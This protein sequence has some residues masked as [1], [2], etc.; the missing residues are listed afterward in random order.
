MIRYNEEKKAN[1]ICLINIF[2]SI[3][4]EAFHAGQPTVFVRTFGCNL[5]CPFCD[6]KECW[7]EANFDKVYEGK[8]KLSWWTVDEII[9]KVEELEKDFP[10]KSICL[11]GGEPLLPE[12]DEVTY[13]LVKKLISL[14]YAVNVETDGAVDYKPWKDRFG[15]AMLIDHDT[16][17]PYLYGNRYGLSLITDWKLPC[18]KMTSMMIESNLSVLDE[19][20]VIKCVIT[21]D[22][23]DWKEFERICKSGTKAKLYL[24]PCFGA[25]TMSK[26][27]EFVVQH[28]EYRITAQIQ[29]HKIF[30]DPSC[31]DV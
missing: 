17:Q 4:G 18:S 13:D 9:A 26:I 3:D 21:D 31:K 22:P 16:M 23:E 14:H 15:K 27:P 5:R 25:V 2:K 11:T 24:S 12:N 7:T 1:E 30:Y 10:Y 8:L 29:Q 19:T 28:P 20:D 6:T